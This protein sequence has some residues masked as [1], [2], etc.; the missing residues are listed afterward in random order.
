MNK[1]VIIGNGFDLAHGMKTRYSDFLLWEINE[2][3]KQPNI[4]RPSSFHIESPLFAI[5]SNYRICQYPSLKPCEFEDIAG[6][7]QYL[8]DNKDGRLIVKVKYSY[9]FIEHLIQF[10][11]QNWVDIEREYYIKLLFVDQ[12]R[13]SK[14]ST[15]RKMLTELNN[16]LNLIKLELERYLKDIKY[17]GYL[18]EVMS[19]FISEIG[20]SGLHL[21]ENVLFL[22]FNYTSTIENYL[23][24]INS[25]FIEVNYIHGKL[26]VE[27]NPLIFG[28]GDETDERYSEIEKLNENDFLEYMKSFAYLQTANYRNL[29]EFLGRADFEVYVMGHS[30]GLSDRLLFNH[31]FEHE[32]FKKVQLYFYEYQNEKGEIVND[33]FQKTQELSRHF[34]LDA[35]HRMRSRVVPFSESKPL[36][37]FKQ[38][39]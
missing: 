24:N 19:C 3:F 11:N 12:L 35:K 14:N 33:F 32:K 13:S 26:E 5:E 17:N 8:K 22:N 31:I 34:K 37:K 39:N 6:F 18:H 23:Q 7:L 4:V 30:L 36:T 2:A 27:N 38:Q 29:F 28:Y 1:L 10:A 16:A 20:I 15:W 21:F 9:P 25:K